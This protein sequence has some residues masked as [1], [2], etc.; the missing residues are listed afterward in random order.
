MSALG[1]NAYLNKPV[2]R[3]K[4]LECFSFLLNP[5]NTNYDNEMITKYR[6]AENH[7]HEYK[8]L[9]AEDNIVNQKVAVKMLEQLGIRADC[10]AN[11]EEAVTAS[12]PYA[13]IALRMGKKL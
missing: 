6:L 9:L 13:R 11:G 2:K 8:I 7:K 1:F 12:S 5:Q 4:L 3:S 10:V